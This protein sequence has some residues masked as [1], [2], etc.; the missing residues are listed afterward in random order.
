MKLLCQT[1]IKVSKYLFSIFVFMLT[2]PHSSL[3]T[4]GGLRTKLWVILIS[5]E[6]IQNKISFSSVYSLALTKYKFLPNLSWN[7]T[8][9]AKLSFS[10][11]SSYAVDSGSPSFLLSFHS[12]GAFSLSVILL[13]HLLYLRKCENSL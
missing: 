9:S 3:W 12:K 4:T 8:F 13:I 7:I 2:Q 6:I 10:Y 11:P 5:I 1:S